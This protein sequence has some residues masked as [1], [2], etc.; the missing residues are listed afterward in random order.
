MVVVSMKGAEFNRIMGYSR[1]IFHGSLDLL[2]EISRSGATEKIYFHFHKHLEGLVARDIQYDLRLPES[3]V[4]KGLN[5]LQDLDL[6]E[7]LDTVRISD[8]GGRDATIWKLK[9]I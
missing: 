7:Q 5:R 2:R 4:Y 9:M 6:I 1:Y 3:T 8:R